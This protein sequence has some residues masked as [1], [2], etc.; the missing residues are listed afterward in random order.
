MKLELHSRINDKNAHNVVK[1][2]E[3]SMQMKFTTVKTDLSFW[4]SAIH[5]QFYV[6]R[7]SNQ[8]PALRKTFYETYILSRNLKKEVH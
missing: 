5:L 4:M 1:C 2:Q 6:C 3:I 7:I 8:E